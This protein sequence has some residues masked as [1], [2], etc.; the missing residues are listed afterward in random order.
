MP[1][2]NG[3][4][5]GTRVSCRQRETVPVIMR[6]CVAREQRARQREAVP[7]IIEGFSVDTEKRGYVK[8]VLRLPLRKSNDSG[9]YWAVWS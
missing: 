5:G 1:V 7:V 9:A 8:A 6:G 3:K 4:A 2:I